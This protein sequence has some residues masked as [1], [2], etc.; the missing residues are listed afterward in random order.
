MFKEDENC[1][2]DWKKWLRGFEIYAR[3]NVIEEPTDKVNWML[4]YAGSKVQSIYDVLPEIEREEMQA[5]PYL[6][7]YVFPQ[8]EYNDAIEKLNKF[9]EPK[10]NES[11]ERHIFR[12]IR[13]KKEERFDMFLVRLRE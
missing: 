6:S 7:G 11:Y 9:F 8:N 10:Q 12:E 3:A 1:G 5:G 13:Q 4:H 2:Y